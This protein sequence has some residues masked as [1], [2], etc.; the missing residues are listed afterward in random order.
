MLFKIIREE[1]ARVVSAVIALLGVL[2]AFG[3]G[4]TDGQV[5]AIVALVGAVLVLFGGEVTR[6]QVV[7]VARQTDDGAYVVTDQPEHV[8][9]VPA[10]LPEDGQH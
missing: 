10:W 5:A 6:A 1:P 3:L 2:T 8:E 9:D 7:P 4:L